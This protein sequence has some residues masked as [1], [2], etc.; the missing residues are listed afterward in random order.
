MKLFSNLTIAPKLAIMLALPILGLGFFSSQSIRQDWQEVQAMETVEESAGLVAEMSELVFRLQA[1]R[2]LTRSHLIAKHEL[3]EQELAAAQK[4]TDEA[5]SAWKTYSAATS[6]EHISDEA[7]TALIV[8]KAKLESLASSRSAALQ[9][10]AHQAGAVYANYVQIIDAQMDVIHHLA[11]H[12]DKASV[13]SEISSLHA[14]LLLIESQGKEQA[15]V[16]AIVIAGNSDKVELETLQEARL[17]VRAREIAFADFAKSEWKVSLKNNN[18][19]PDSLLARSVVQT[20]LVNQV[21]AAPLDAAEYWKAK[22]AVMDGFRDIRNDIQV[23]VFQTVKAAKM[24]SLHAFQW[25][26]SLTAAL[27][28]AVLGISFSIGRG[29]RSRLREA[30]KVT[31]LV[32]GGDLTTE[33]DCLGSDE[34]A[35]VMQG[36]HVMTCS[37]RELIG[38]VKVSEGK[39]TS[40]AKEFGAQTN[41]LRATVIEQDATTHEIVATSNQISATS[42]DLL[43]SIRAVSETADE[44]AS[45]ASA[46]LG[47]LDQLGASMEGISAASGQVVDKL[48]ELNE[49]AGNINSVTSLIAKVADQT[50]L[51]SLNAAI[52]AEKAGEYGSGFSVVATEIRRLADQTAVAVLEIEQTVKEIQ[53]AVSAG[54]MSMDKFSMQ[55]CTGLEKAKDVSEHLKGVISKVECM[56]AQ[57]RSVEESMEQQSTG[58]R[59]ISEAMAQLGEN[60]SHTRESMELSTEAILGLE[61]AVAELK[62]GVAHFQVDV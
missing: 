60:S 43:K 22:T 56:P 62:E 51:L 10:G 26:L 58:A 3:F 57:F 8:S 32:A 34:T 52:E 46:G 13:Q 1:E 39:V 41:E 31:D 53:A 40:G 48:S 42:V 49:K 4:D 6:F 23:E 47:S 18:Q 37:L 11:T 50:N 45:T 54:V 21:G 44:T 2:G 59:Q 36:L 28:L 29:I 14:L 27:L 38:Q 30:M 12:V 5:L 24:A 20:I 25:E 16:T 19:T 7:Q 61:E 9:P 55:A 17:M 33:M 35:Q 15:V